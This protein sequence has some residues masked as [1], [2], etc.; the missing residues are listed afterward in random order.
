LLNALS[1]LEDH[2]LLLYGDNYWPIALDQMISVYNETGAPVLTTVFSNTHGTGEYGLENNTEVGE[3]FIVRNYD[4]T[5]GSP[6]LNG[7][8]MGYFI[9]EKEVLDPTLDDNVS[10]EEDIFADLAR[11]GLVSAYMTDVQYYYI[12]DIQSVR[13]FEDFVAGN[14]IEHVKL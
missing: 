2:F 13:A 5:R 6:G 9:V 11:R 8:D 7:V 4:K 3:D 14:D 12:T 10:F 1:S